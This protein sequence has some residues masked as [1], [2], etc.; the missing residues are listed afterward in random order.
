[1]GA[2]ATLSNPATFANNLQIFLDRNFLEALKYTLKFYT[3]ATK[4]S[5]PGNAGHV[6]VRFFRERRANTSGINTMGVDYNEGAVPT[7]LTEVG[8]GYV[9]CYLNQRIQISKI[10]DVVL[11]TD[12][13][14]TV[15]RYSSKLGEDAALYYDTICANSMFANPAVAGNGI[16][17]RQST[18]YGSNGLFERFSGVDNKDQNGAV[19]TSATRFGEL[20]AL[21]AANSRMNRAFHIGCLTQLRANDVP[22]VNGRY[23]VVTAPEVINDMRQDSQWFSAAV[24]NAEKLKLFQGGEFELDGGVFVETT[25]AFREGA[26]YGTRS[27]TGGIYTAAYMGKDAF[28]VPTLSNGKAGGSG[29]APLTTIVTKPDHTNPAGQWVTLSSKSYFGSILLLTNEATDKPHVVGARVQTTI[30][31]G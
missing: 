21:S 28:G 30:D 6:S 2:M 24:Y 11:A 16:D 20:K 15:G 22:M 18:L 19:K 29:E 27:D 31:V 26:T 1:M 12:I 3:Y 14:P 9:D 17:S 13:V 23:V 8:R 25:R 10:S 5:V 7:N 4:K